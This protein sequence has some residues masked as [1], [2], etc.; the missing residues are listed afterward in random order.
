MGVLFFLLIIFV[1]SAGL[2]IFFDGELSQIWD[3]EKEHLKKKLQ[4]IE[5]IDLDLYLTQTCI[6]AEQY[7]NAK[8]LLTELSL[9]LSIAPEKLTFKEPFKSYFCSTISELDLNAKQL[10]ICNSRK[11][12]IFYFADEEDFIDA[13]SCFYGFERWHQIWNEQENLPKNKYDLF[14]F[15]FEMNPEEFLCFFTPL[16]TDSK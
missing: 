4:G 3:I 8:R 1:I 13:L 2:L 7:K 11:I 15:I 12:E 6:P 14:N 5:S 10:K 9:D 16:A